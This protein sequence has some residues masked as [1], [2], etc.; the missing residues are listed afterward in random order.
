VAALA[1][2]AAAS[3][4]LG[5][6][7]SGGGQDGFTIGVLLPVT[8]GTG[9]FG[10]FDQ[11]LIEQRLH[12]LCP[13]CHVEIVSAMD[14]AATQEQQIN[15]M[16]TEKVKVM[17]LAAVAPLTLRSAVTSAHQA[18]IPVVAY[19]RLAE[20][21]IAGFV[22]YDGTQVG[23]LQGEGLLQAMGSSASG[24]R[25]VMMNGDSSD[26]NSALFTRG[27]LSVL[28]GKVEIVRSYS[29]LNWQQ[30]NAYANMTSA[31][32]ALGTNSVEGVLAAND[33]LATGVVNALQAARVS[34]LPPVTGQDAD[35]DAVQRI[36]GGEQYMTVYKPFKPEAYAAADMAMA[37]TR[38]QSLAGIAHNTVDNSTT[39][40]IPAVLLTPTAV[41]SGNIKNT[42]V[43]DGMYTISEICTP[44]LRPACAQAGLL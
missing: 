4:Q 24:G 40:H 18:G 38:G 35:L 23:R 8:G 39:R 37:L 5:G 13:A 27:A 10:R 36:V 15:T 29:T 1:V 14:D 25:I 12:Q 41:T 7:T 17:I 30:A 21:P 43:K 6:C 16:I 9:R 33:N 34:P 20:G 28:A 22:T 31:I 44:I 42:V 2:C 19:D 3:V 11:P 26:P 32:A